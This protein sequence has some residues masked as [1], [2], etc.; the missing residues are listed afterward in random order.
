VRWALVRNLTQI[1]QAHLDV[2]RTLIQK[3]SLGLSANGV[4]LIVWQKSFKH[5]CFK[6]NES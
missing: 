4:L 2:E 1:P 3:D 5:S 6:K